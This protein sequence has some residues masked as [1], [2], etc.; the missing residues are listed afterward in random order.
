MDTN[1]NNVLKKCG[2]CGI[3]KE[4]NELLKHNKKICKNCN[5]EQ[6]RNRYNQDAEHR[7]KLIIQSTI[8]KQKKI[9]ERRQEK[10]LRLGVGNKQCNYCDEIKASDKFRH[11]RL[12]CKVC[13]RDDPKEKFKRVIRTRIYNALLR[14][15]NKHTIE[16]L[17][18]NPDDYVKWI[19]Y[20][21]NGYT[22]ENHGCIWHI[23]HVIPLSL[24]N[25]HD[26]QQQYLAFNWRNTSPLS[27]KENL[28][29]NN[30]ISLPQ[31]EDHIKLLKKYHIE[32]KI[33]LPQSFVGLFA[34]YLVAGTP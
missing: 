21:S 11:N 4:D 33:D 10:E 29:K 8:H 13:E 16:Y 28:S 7:E 17:G 19:H 30:K 27:I 22:I 34:K 32:N 26:E 6:R 15:K 31:L 9:I 20:N 12:K 1:L 2:K 5:N 18:V 14:N 25:L 3:E 23:D 24:F